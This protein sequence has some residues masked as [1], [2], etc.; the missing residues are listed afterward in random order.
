MFPWSEFQTTVGGTSNTPGD[1]RF[2]M[3]IG[4][5]DMLPGEVKMLTTAAIWGRATSNTSGITSSVEVLQSCADEIQSIF[6]NCFTIIPTGISDKASE[7]LI[8]LYPNPANNFFEI[9]LVNSN[10]LIKN[11]ILYN[12]TGER[13]IDK[14]ELDGKSIRI[15]TSPLLSGIYYYSVKLKNGV[16]KS[17]KIVISGH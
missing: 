9:K 17:G 7:E 12:S 16:S 5:F 4:K 1:R 15:D 3:S 11:I 14:K 8:H 6:D 2:L 10:Q 13:V